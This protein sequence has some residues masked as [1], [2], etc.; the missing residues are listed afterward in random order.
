MRPFPLWLMGKQLIYIM[1][2]GE[3]RR[4]WDG[5]PGR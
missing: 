3:R 1:L 4:R 5:A 2:E